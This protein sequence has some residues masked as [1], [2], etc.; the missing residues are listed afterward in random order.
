MKKTQMALAAVALVAST[1]A[2]AEVKVFGNLD[3]GYASGAN[4][5]FYGAGNNATTQFG[6]SGSEDIGGGL[7]ASFNLLSGIN[8]AKGAMGDNGGG[9]TNLFNRGASVGVSN[10]NVGITIGNQF[11]NAVL[12]AGF[13]TGG[14]GVGGDGINVP[15]VVRLFGGSAGAVTQGGTATGFFIPQALQVSANV[16]GIS[17]NLMYRMVDKSATD[18]SYMGLTASTS[19]SG[20]NVAVGYQDAGYATASS[21]YKSYFIAANTNFGDVRV[22]VAA[23]DNSGAN[24]SS[25]YSLGAS[26][27]LAAGISGGVSYANGTDTQGSQTGLALEYALSKQSKVYANYLTFSKAGGGAAIAN[28]GNLTITGKSLTTV[29]LSHAF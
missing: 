23:A 2:M 10:E 1:V 24:K 28:D 21:N 14:N 13:A 27:P 16:A 18:S 26:M 11:S 9:N 19:V 6:I 20:I 17:S 12:A 7:K 4:S 25:T 3:G 15:A 22:N 8:I 29:G 5:K